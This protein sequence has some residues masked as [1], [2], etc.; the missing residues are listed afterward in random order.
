MRVPLHASALV[1]ALLPTLDT[2]N[3]ASRKPEK[4]VLL[5]DIQS[6]TFRAGKN[7]AAR[8]VDAIPQVRPPR[9]ISVH[10]DQPN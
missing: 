1:L 10:T 5:A 8:R 7:T 3:A 2:V 9:S 4:A 6:L